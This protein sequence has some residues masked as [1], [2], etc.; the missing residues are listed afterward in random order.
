MSSLWGH[1]EAGLAR[2]RAAP[3]SVGGAV[4]LLV[5]WPM[6]ILFMFEWVM[7]LQRSP[8]QL[9][10]TLETAA[11]KFGRAVN[12]LGDLGL[13]LAAGAEE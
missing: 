5:L 7:V 10:D 2:G 11:D 3:P 4:I 1:V 6:I 8:E 13:V 9:E 12:F